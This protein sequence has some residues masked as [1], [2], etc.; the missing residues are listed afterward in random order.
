[1]FKKI[2]WNKWGFIPAVVLTIASALLLQIMAKTPRW[3]LHFGLDGIPNRFGSSNELWILVFFQVIFIAAMACLDEGM[4]RLRTRKFNI[5]GII[6]SGFG[7]IMFNVLLQTFYAGQQSAPRLSP[8]F[9]AWMIASFLLPG[10][11]S[12]ILERFRKYPENESIPSHPFTMPDLTQRNWIYWENYNPWWINAL[13]TGVLVMVAAPRLMILH[14][15]FQFDMIL[16]SA[17]ILISIFIGGFQ[18]IINSQQ[19]SVTFGWLKIPCLKIKMT[20]IATVEAVEFNALTRFGGWGFKYTP[21][22]GWGFILGNNGVMLRTKKDRRFT[23]ST[24]KP[25]IVAEIIKKV[26]AGQ[27]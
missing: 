18:L 27:N 4:L 22:G 3:P 5:A 21:W 8:H 26:I 16:L 7:G 2:H 13:L 14:S 6:V 17:F 1:M 10:L 11:A 25:E 23:I 15:N 12:Y 20:N 19:F 9:H 24:K